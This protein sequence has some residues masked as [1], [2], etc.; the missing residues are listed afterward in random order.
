[1]RAVQIADLDKLRGASKNQ[2]IQMDYGTSS[3]KAMRL[4]HAHALWVSLTKES[5]IPRPASACSVRAIV[6]GVQPGYYT[7]FRG[8]S[9]DMKS[10]VVL[11]IGWSRFSLLSLAKYDSKGRVPSV[12][13]AEVD[14]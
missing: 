2:H 14:L 10:S 12:G 11:C 9:I 5:S 3:Q 8:V 6:G 13:S 7:G 4:E 1:M